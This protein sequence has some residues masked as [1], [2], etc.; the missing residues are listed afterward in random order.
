VKLDRARAALAVIDVQEGFRTAVLDFERVAGNVAVLV[1]GARILGLP[2][3]VTE[4]YPKGLGAT[5]P[6]VARHLDGIEPIEKVSFSAFDADGFPAALADDRDQ[7]VLCGI[8]AHVCVNQTA[9]DLLATGREVHVVQDAVSSRT[10]ENRELG[11]HKME[12]GGAVVTSVE[13]ALFELLREAGTP[14]FKQIQT[15]V[16]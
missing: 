1:E 9:E 5:V 6:E 7:V 4:Q 8:E 2:V 11:L 3:L 12:R 14:E 13:T 15:L 10:A 16:K